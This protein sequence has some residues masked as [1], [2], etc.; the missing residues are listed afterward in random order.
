MGAALLA[1][2][3]AGIGPAGAD[4]LGPFCDPR[5]PPYDID[6]QGTTSHLA[7]TYNLWL[8]SYTTL[9]P[10]A[11]GAVSYAGT[12][13]AFASSAMLKREGQ[14][15][16]R[17]I[18][19]TPGEQALIE[20]DL[21][22]SGLQNRSAHVQHLP[23]FVSALAVAY[24]LDCAATSVRIPG[25]VLAGMFAGTIP[26]WNDP[27]LVRSNPALATCDR[28]V[29]LAVRAEEAGST[30]VFKDYLA[31]R[32]PLFRPYT[33][34]QLNTSWPPAANVVCEG[35]GD[36]GVAGC[37][38]SRRGTIG[39]VALKV[40]VNQGLTLAQVD[41][42]AGQF[43]APSLPGCST[44]ANASALP[45]STQGDWSNVSLTNPTSGYA[46]CSLSFV[47]VWDS[48]GQAYQPI[49]TNPPQVRNVRDYLTVVLSDSVQ[50]KLPTYGVAA[51]PARVLAL[52][53]SGVAAITYP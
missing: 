14:F 27:L 11:L 5:N 16:G 13:D 15:Y 48:Y 30:T 41:N 26:K 18:P 53:R 28:D 44:A 10:D 32:L 39:Y 2:V 35:A 6:G 8:P 33:Q 45:P 43:S 40:A 22:F 51:L 23:V 37:V 1:A 36:A 21:D 12:S 34:P 20:Y 50:A 17:D 9:C 7:L 42:A 47:L 31:K 52:S 29:R 19:L 24:N 38:A 3:A 25:E 4:D 49:N 46:L